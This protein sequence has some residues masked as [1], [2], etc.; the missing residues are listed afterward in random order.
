MQT[1]LIRRCPVDVSIDFREMFHGSRS[2]N[3]SDTERAVG[4]DLVAV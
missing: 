2:A 1:L 3:Q 4:F